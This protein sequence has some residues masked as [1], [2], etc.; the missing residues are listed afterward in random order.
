MLHRGL[1]RIRLCSY[2]K[3]A[4]GDGGNHWGFPRIIV[5]TTDVEVDVDTLWGY[6]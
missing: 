2:T 5:L 1:Y 6:L 4:G 3:C